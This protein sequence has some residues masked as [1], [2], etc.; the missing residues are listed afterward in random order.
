MCQCESTARLRSRSSHCGG[1]RSLTTRR[2]SMSTHHRARA[3]GFRVRAV[4]LNQDSSC[5]RLFGVVVEN[6]HGALNDDRTVVEIGRHEVHGDAVDLDAVIRAPAAREDQ[7][8]RQKRGWML[9]M[10][11]GKASISGGPTFA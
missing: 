11:L 3:S 10:A 5:E 4:L 1:S 6:R 2:P 8:R 7:E 9:R